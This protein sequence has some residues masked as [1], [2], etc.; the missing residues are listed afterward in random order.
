MLIDEMNVYDNRKDFIKVANLLASDETSHKYSC[1]VSIDHKAMYIA[2]WE[3]DIVV[4]S[5]DGLYVI[6]V[7]DNINYKKRQFLA[8]DYT[9]IAKLVRNLHMF[10]KFYAYANMYA[11][12]LNDSDFEVSLSFDGTD[13]INIHVMNVDTFKIAAT[14]E[15]RRISDGS[16]KYRYFG[17]YGEYPVGSPNKLIREF[18]E[19]WA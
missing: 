11:Y 16:F 8:C 17:G 6:N 19:G 3:Y 7:Y 14:M 4:K 18:L 10:N 9:R 13:Y 1:N 15:I 12:L 2:S 5:R